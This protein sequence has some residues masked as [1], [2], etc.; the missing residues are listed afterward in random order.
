M[1]GVPAAIPVEKVF[2]AD[3]GV[4]QGYLIFRKLDPQI[5]EMETMLNFNFA[6]LQIVQPVSHIYIYIT[7][8]CLEYFKL[9]FISYEKY[10]TSQR[11]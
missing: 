6:I 1:S 10:T 11:S 5:V 8:V 7:Y 9:H 3:Q 2:K 4:V